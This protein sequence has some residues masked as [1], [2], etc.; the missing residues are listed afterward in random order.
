MVAER[1]AVRY[2]W[3]HTPSVPMMTDITSAP[4][5]VT[6][7]SPRAAAGEASIPVTTAMM[8]ATHGAKQLTD[9]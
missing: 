2:G 7:A 6:V 1:P 3:F 5:S 8:M 4:A 9:M